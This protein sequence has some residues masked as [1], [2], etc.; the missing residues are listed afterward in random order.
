[1]DTLLD[2]D[3]SKDNP[4]NFI[5]HIIRIAIEQAAVSIVIT[6]KDGDIQ[7][8]NPAFE[9]ITGYTFGEVIGGNPR[10]LKSGLTTDDVFDNLW[11]T[12]SSGRPWKGELINRRKDG[13][14]YYEEA[15]ISPIIDEN[16]EITNYLGVKQD[17]TTQKYLEEKLRQTSIRDPLTNAYNRGYVFERLYQSI[18]QYK[19]EKGD[20]VVAILDIDHFKIVNDT[21]GHQAG[22][23][24]LREFCEILMSSIRSY[25]TLGRYG[26]EEFIILFHDSD[27]DR[28]H[29]IMERILDSIRKYKFRYE[30]EEISITFS[31]GISNAFEF[32]HKDITVK[33]LIDLADI[34]LYKAKDAGRNMIVI[35]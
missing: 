3:N 1:M 32:S 28:V 4:K 12:I 10:I 18:E 24:V 29:E 21:F 20:F 22:D 23:Y 13:S 34:R 30:D 31:C 8:V 9:S 35:D 17:I 7:Y 25:D 27:K 14:I 19:R 2:K 5:D 33:D 26:G 15:R 11:E 16:G 6:D